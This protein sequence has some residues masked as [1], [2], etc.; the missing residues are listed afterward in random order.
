MT[1]SAGQLRA[2][3]VVVEGCLIRW[4]RQHHVVGHR[5]AVD[6]FGVGLDPE[7][8][9]AGCGSGRV[10]RCDD[11]RFFGQLSL[12]VVVAKLLAFVLLMVAIRHDFNLFTEGSASGRGAGGALLVPLVEFAIFGYGV[13]VMAA[14][15]MLAGV[16]QPGR[17]PRN[18]PG[19]IIGIA[20]ICCWLVPHWQAASTAAA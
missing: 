2:S 5:V 7:T 14:A 11:H 9:R 6:S 16:I 10:W 12:G 3:R 13:L 1:L 8:D 17:P 18:R 15:G 4:R 19:A 20:G